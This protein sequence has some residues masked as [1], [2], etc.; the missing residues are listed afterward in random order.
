MKEICLIASYTPTKEKEDALRNLVRKLKS[1]NKTIL[2]V[3]HSSNTP[4]DIISDVDYYF[5]DYQ[6]EYPDGEKYNSF[7]YHE[8]FNNKTIVSKD[9]IKRTTSILPCTRNL[10]FGLTISKMLGYDCTHYIEYDTDLSDV[11]LIDINT[12]K[13]KDY[14]VIYYLTKMGFGEHNSH[15]YGPYSVYNLSSYTYEELKW[16]REIILDVFCDDNNNSLVEKVTHSILVNGKKYLSYDVSELSK[17][18]IKFD[19][20][21]SYSDYVIDPK[22]LFV[23]GETFTVFCSNKSNITEEYEIIVNGESLIMVGDIK[24]G[25]FALQPIG[26]IKDVKSVKLYS[27]GKLMFDYEF[28]NNE[29]IEKLIKNNYIK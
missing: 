6:N 10:L 19:T 27:N 1:F 28:I 2:L 13:I 22:I 8:N 18:N 21:K 25:W 24:P 16:D 12:T 7:W 5:Y 4:Q 23:D 26:N 20:I 11:E 15:F 14:D 3:T 17:Y 9:I 29:S